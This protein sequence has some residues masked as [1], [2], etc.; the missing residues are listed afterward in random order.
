MEIVRYK[1][2]FKSE[3]TK[4]GFMKTAQLFTTNN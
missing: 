2:N 3:E 4:F 1:A